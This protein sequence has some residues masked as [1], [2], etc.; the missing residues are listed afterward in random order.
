MAELPLQER[1]QPSLLDRLTDHQPDQQKVEPPERR[2]MARGQLRKLVMRD[3]AWLF[4]AIQFESRT[5]LSRWPAARRSVLNFGLP[6]LA[7]HAA[8]SLD[9]SALERA[10]RQTILDFE[11]RI[12]P[13]TLVVR[14]LVD[15]GQ[16][17]HNVI[18]LQ[19]QGHVWGQPVPIEMLVRTEIDLDTGEVAIADLLS[20]TVT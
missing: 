7:G 3:L 15:G 4:N 5:D 18:G 6:A 16:V 17:E 10:V 19:I 2:V 11:P 20:P 13:E 9:L 8:S 12:L 1:L 14:A